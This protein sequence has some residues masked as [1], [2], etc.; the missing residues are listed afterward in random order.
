MLKTSARFMQFSVQKMFKL[1]ADLLFSVAAR[2]SDITQ[3]AAVCGTRQFSRYIMP[4]KDITPGASQTTGL[5][6]RNNRMYKDD[7]E[8]ATTTLHVA[9]TAFLDFIEQCSCPPVLVGHNIASYDAPVL[10]HSL[11]Q[12]G[13][14]A[15]VHKAT[16]GCMDTLQLA[17]KKFP[18]PYGQEHLVKTLL[19]KEYAAHDALGDVLALKELYE[20]QLKLTTDEMARHVFDMLASYH[21]SSLDILISEKI[22]SKNMSIKLAR[23]G[24]G[25]RALKLAYERESDSGIKILLSQQVSGKP[26]VTRD[27]KI[28]EKICN[29]LSKH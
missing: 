17:R 7:V 21:R 26:R 27:T 13:M 16:A 22:V 19:G 14:V 23:N 29:Y 3:L 11:K 2:S 18:K 10:L 9:L 15:A 4:V 28:V 12:C 25:L 6:V 8:V 1:G 20:K 5:R 24:L